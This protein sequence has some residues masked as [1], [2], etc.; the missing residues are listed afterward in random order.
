MHFVDVWS[1]LWSYVTPEQMTAIFT[2]ILSLSTIGLWTATGRLSALA[3]AQS[4]DMKDSIAEAARAAT[5]M[6]NVAIHIETNA[7]A[8]NDSVASL[9]ERTAQ[10]MRAYVGI[11]PGNAIY[12][13][14]NRNLHFEGQPAMV[15][16]G[17]TPAHKVSYWA[18]SAILLGLNLL[19]FQFHCPRTSRSLPVKI[20][21][22][23][24]P[25]FGRS[26]PLR[27]IAGSRNTSMTRRSLISK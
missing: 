14:R 25:S 26:R 7:K 9:R 4:R 3:A 5:A 10:Q 1:H 24:P 16:T 18:Q 27:S 6:E 21:R 12:Q 2:V 8:A 15:N 23:M 19:F 20:R 13:E 17:H 11:T 22:V